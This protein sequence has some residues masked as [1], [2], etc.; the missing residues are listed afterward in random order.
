MVPTI[1]RFWMKVD[2]SGDCWDWTASTDAY[3]YGA[4]GL[5]GRMVKAHRFSYQ[6]EHGPITREV[7]ICHTCDN[8]KCVRPSHLYPGS[9]LTNNR[10]TAARGRH[11]K[12][13][14][15]HCPQGHEYTDENTRID[16]GHRRC[17]ECR[18]A[19]GRDYYQRV[20]KKR[21]P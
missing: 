16:H 6:L 1:E 7:H 2:T 12:Q 8:R 14:K 4:F 10:D 3:G 13:R 5:N 18:K 15:T 20:T 11:A 21:V 19:E 17:R 9:P